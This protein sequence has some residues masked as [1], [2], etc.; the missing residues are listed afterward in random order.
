MRPRVVVLVTLSEVGGAQ[1][2][3]ARLAATL[4]STYEVVVAAQGQGPLAEAVRAS[5]GRFVELRHMRRAPSPWRDPLAFW[6][7]VRLL[8]RERPQIV[9]ANSSKAGILGRLAGAVVGVPSRVFTAHGWAFHAH[10]GL[11]AKLYLAVE[12][13]VAPLT[14]LTIC[15]A[16]SELESGVAAGVCLPSR[17]VV[18]ANAVPVPPLGRRPAHDPPRVLTVGRLKPPK[19]FSTLLRAVALLRP[20]ACR[21]VVAGAGPDRSRLAVEAE[22]LGIAGDVEFLGERDDIAALL[23]GCDVFVLSS[24]SE[25]MPMSV[26][27]AMA[28]GVPVVASAVGG[29]PEAVGEAGLLVPAAEPA[30]LAAALARVAG[31]AALRDRL[32]RAGRARVQH[33]FP[34]DVWRRTHLELYAR[35]AGRSGRSLAPPGGAEACIPQPESL[36]AADRGPGR[37]SGGGS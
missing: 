10:S 11:A 14:T 23:D 24:R 31:D 16:A 20:G 37:R 6:E 15:V 36:L 30:A 3:V 27:E 5:G 13:L 1:T 25:A 18:C 34:L 7:I 26:L 4:S 21:L 8:R 35:E 2:Y 17:T 29:V 32:G 19:D 33:H 9:H 22:A 12:R 28:A